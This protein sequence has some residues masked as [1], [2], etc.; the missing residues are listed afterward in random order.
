MSEEE[1]RETEEWTSET[2]PCPLCGSEYICVFKNPVRMTCQVHCWEASCA[3]GKGNEKEDLIIFLEDQETDK[4]SPEDIWT[5]AR[6]IWYETV[7]E[8]DNKT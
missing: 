7:L 8:Y 5:I 2:L 6:E 3:F 1:V 4:L